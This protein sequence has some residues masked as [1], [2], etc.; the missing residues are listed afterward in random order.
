MRTRSP[1]TACLILATLPTTGCYAWTAVPSADVRAGLVEVRS[2]RL[3]FRSPAE[4][5]ELTGSHVDRDQVVGWDAARGGERRV[6]LSAPWQVEVR[7]PDRAATAAVYFGGILLGASV[8]AGL[9]LG[10]AVLVSPVR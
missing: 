5:V 7:R 2:R 8:V 6:D 10:V 3:R 4:T 1:L 9:A